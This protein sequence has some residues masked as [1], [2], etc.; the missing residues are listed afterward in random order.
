[1]PRADGSVV[2]NTKLN[3]QGFG[4]EIPGLKSQFGSLG[5]AVKKLA[6]AVA[7]AF[8]VKAIISFGK[9][10]VKLGSDLQEVQN[11]VDVTF[12][13]MNE[14]VNNFAKNAA[15]TAGLSETMAKRY[16]GS[17]G[18]MAKS[19]RFTEA[20]AYE[21]ST[22]LAQLSGDVASFYNIT[23]D[24][25]YTKLASVFTGETESLKELGVV[26]TQTALDDF[27]MRKGIQKTTSQMT[28]QEKVALR[29]Q[30]VLEQLNGA[31]GDFLRTSDSWANQTRLLSLQF[32]Q[33]KATLGQG[34]IN[35]LTPMIKLLN[36]LIARAQVL[37]DK[38]LAFTNAIFGNAGGSSSAAVLGETAESAETLAGNLQESE[39]AAQKAKKALAGFDEITKLSSGDKD[40]A[41]TTVSEVKL[42][43]D[44]KEVKKADNAFSALGK[45]FEKFRKILEP[46]KNIDFSKLKK[47]LNGLWEA[48]KPFVKRALSGLEWLLEEI[49]MPLSAWV[50]EDALP[51][52][53]DLVS[54]ALGF[55]DSI[56][57][58]IQPTLD[59]LWKDII[60]PMASFVGDLFIEFL[61]LL[62]GVFQSLSSWAT[63]NEGVVRNLFQLFLGFLAGVW[64]YNTGKNLIAFVGNLGTAFKLLGD[65][66]AIS[67]LK[68]GFIAAAIMILAAG[69]IEVS[70]VWNK[71]TPAE[72]VVT[73]LTALA[74]AATAAA[75][76]IALFHTSWSAG[77]A[78]AAIVG[79][80]SLL[81]ISFVLKDNG[82]T[83]EAAK[84]S[85]ESFYNSYDWNQ[86]FDLPQLA[87][88]AVIP[89]NAPFAAIL[90]DQ[91]H[92]TNIEAPLSTIQE[93]VA[94]VMED[95][96]AAN[97][98]GH[99][100]TVAVL[101]DILEAVL[102]IHVGDDVIGQ[103][104]SR[105][106]AKMSIIRGG[107]V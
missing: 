103:A 65:K 67:G 16:V 71:M 44:S 88:G 2:I 73:I 55:L 56:L 84:A 93:A 31:S 24:Q 69:I 101:R 17:F 85:A 21:M 74:A 33:L 27:A 92:G 11:V 12:T 105:Y 36:T 30:F 35:I 86:N 45:T 59:W 80:L 29:Y 99:E 102:G 63:E 20:E 76:A 22:S 46:L 51:V 81:G 100:A 106:N 77:L 42:D 66:L 58:A 9:E 60:Q 53:L 98:A 68:A 83:A 82:S 50:L 72:H 62:V 8:S 47:S 34:F 32:D 57:V 6:V 107:S 95:Y 70:K 87:K 64:V 28:E 52:F 7:A 14:Q 104:V 3:T 96:A 19:F 49:L 48:F 40:V 91:R 26:M 39:K 37:A 97:M 43:Y 10:A 23:Q 13:T 90:G 15:A 18:A 1:M 61:N 75:I 4:K 5:S 54:A 79:G 25:A 94:L 38:F 89:P 78:A 41:S